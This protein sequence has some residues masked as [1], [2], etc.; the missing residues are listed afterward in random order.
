MKPWSADPVL[1]SNAKPL[2]LCVEDDSRQLMLRK[3]VLE[4]HGFNVVGASNAADA[5]AIFREA[6]VC[7][8][9]ADH[10]LEGHSGVELAKYF[11]SIKRDVPMILYSG[12]MPNDLLNIDVYINKD[13]PTAEFLRIVHEV[14][15]RFCS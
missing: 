5:V 14:V 11:K 3:A 4:E 13:V 8:T 1:A 2:I 12:T 15:R 9:I 7:C 10:A 6:P